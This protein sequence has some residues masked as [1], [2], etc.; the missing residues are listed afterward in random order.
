V[1]PIGGTLW[2]NLD[3]TALPLKVFGDERSL[4]AGAKFVRLDGECQRDR[5]E[6]G[7]QT[8]IAACPI[9]WPVRCE[10]EYL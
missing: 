7:S 8:S 4:P 3:K 6:G 5:A 2:G 1:L 10:S 9:V